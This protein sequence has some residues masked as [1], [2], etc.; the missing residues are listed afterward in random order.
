[1]LSKFPRDASHICWT[2]GE[3]PL[4]IT[5]ELDERTFLCDGKRIR[6]LRGLGWIHWVDLVLSS[7]FA[8]IE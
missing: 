4:V 2:P 1:V 6:H 7:V 3:H 5:E 8:G